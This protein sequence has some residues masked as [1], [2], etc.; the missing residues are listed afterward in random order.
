M[1]PRSALAD[2]GCERS[3][4]NRQAFDAAN[5]FQLHLRKALGQK[6]FDQG[7]AVSGDQITVVSPM[8]GLKMQRIHVVLPRQ[9]FL[10]M[11]ELDRDRC[12]PFVSLPFFVMKRGFAL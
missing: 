9:N 6:A 7:E 3:I 12:G 8:Q 4:V 10:T 5:Q 1:I 11:G 2:L